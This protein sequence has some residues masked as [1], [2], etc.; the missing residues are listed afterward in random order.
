[1]SASDRNSRDQKSRDHAA[2][3][4]L[5][6]WLAGHPTAARD[7][8]S[9]VAEEL[10]DAGIA[11]DQVSVRVKDRHSYLAKLA[12]PAYPEYRD[13]PSAHDIL[14]IRVTT[15]HSSALPQLLDV[16]GSM[17]DV[18]R[19]V[20]KASETAQAGEF[21][22]A[23]QHVIARVREETLPDIAGRLVEVQLRTVLQHA[24]AEFEH[25][26]RYKNP[27]AGLSP[28]IHRAFTLA[29]G[30]IELADQQFDD[31]AAALEVGT[32][33]PDDA[34]LTTQTLPGVLTMLLGS[35]YPTSR[36]EYYGFAV[37]MLAANGITTIGELEAL[38][39]PAR[40][41]SLRDTMR[42][43]FHPGQVRFIDD[44]LLHTYGREHIQRTVH[45]GEDPSSRPGRLG[46]RWQRM[47]QRTYRPR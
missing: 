21:G 32:R 1:M 16:I 47:G 7:L 25:D 4:D 31:I 10:R 2:L 42:Y 8:Q 17:F 34:E 46:N 33:S 41:Q 27:Q 22:Y 30:L 37:D 26:I 19:V 43:S 12:N 11:F 39:A 36:A 35:E 18:V 23:S 28:R 6:S 40:V 38:C 29:A 14:G 5:D 44:L 15:F 24:W 9:L 3:D 13:F 20:D 45:I